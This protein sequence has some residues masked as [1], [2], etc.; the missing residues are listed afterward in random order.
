MNLTEIR[1]QIDALDA[2][3]TAL[4][5]RRLDLAGQVAAYKAANGLPVLNEQREQQVLEQVRADSDARDTD[6]TGYASA[7]A[8]V[9]Q[10]MMDVSR[11]LQ[12]RRLSAGEALRK[13]LAEAAARELLP[14]DRARVVCAGRPAA[15]AHEAARRIFGTACMPEFVTGFADVVAAVRD[16][17]ADYGVLP[18]ENSS[19]GSVNEVYDLI[20]AN[21]FSIVAAVE[22]PVQHC[23]LARPGADPAKLKVVYSHHQALAQCADYIAAHGL[24]PR[25]YSNTAAA[26][27]MVAHS[28]DNTLCA[29]ASET[30]G[31]IYGLDIIEN[32]IQTVDNNCTRFIVIAAEAAIPADADKITMTFSIPHSTGSLYRILSRFAM[33][34]MNLTKIESRPIKS[35]EF[36]YVFY[37]DFEGNLRQPQTVDLLCA[38]SEETRHFVFMGNYHEQTLPRT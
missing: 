18:I 9:F 23:L 2:E 14:A 21:R 25:Q 31:D 22:V 30:A 28:T 11:A 6:G 37:L 26:A 10:T 17:T 7:N 38:L 27:E 16:G 8:L 5:C 4:L 24:E 34:G 13:Q 36:E 33:E 1:A 32:N 12:H 29:I 20:M 3:L 19:T 15:Y 35:G